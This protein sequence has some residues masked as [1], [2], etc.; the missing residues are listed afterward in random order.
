MYMICV[1]TVAKMSTGGFDKVITYLII[2]IVV[3]VFVFFQGQS[4]FW[5]QNSDSGSSV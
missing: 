5:V 2:S 1:Y 3:G 4:Q